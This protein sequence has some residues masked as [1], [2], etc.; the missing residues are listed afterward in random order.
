MKALT[1]RK[2]LKLLLG[3][4]ILM[5]SLVLLL[6]PSGFIS[7]KD[8][9]FGGGCWI[10]GY[11]PNTGED[12]TLIVAAHH[13]VGKYFVAEVTDSNGNSIVA[14][15]MYYCIEDNFF[16]GNDFRLGNLDYDVYHAKVKLYNAIDSE[17]M[18]VGDPVF[19]SAS[20]F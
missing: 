8:P 6:I 16:I 13:A 11:N 20:F 3:S 4:I 12:V 18:P 10:I 17:G 14:D 15:P 19:T 2:S 5:F 9:P 7:Q 1:K